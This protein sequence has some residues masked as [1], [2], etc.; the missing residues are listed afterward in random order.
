MFPCCPLRI[1]ETITEY[2]K[3]YSMDIPRVGS[4]YF[5][6]TCLAST[7]VMLSHGGVDMSHGRKQLL[8]DLRKGREHSVEGQW[9]LGF[10]LAECLLQSKPD[11]DLAA[12]RQEVWEPCL[13]LVRQR[14]GED[15]A[16]PPWPLP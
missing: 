4:L 6:L 11:I 14:C 3:F 15:V 1:K 10:S 12:M 9:P 2:T 13:Q 8:D 5:D 7:L 16:A